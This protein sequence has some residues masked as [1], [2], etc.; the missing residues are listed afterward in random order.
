[1]SQI[2]ICYRRDD[3]GG[4]TGRLRDALS[5]EFGP[6]R[7]F[8]DLDTIGPGDDFI[9]AIERGVASCAVFLAIV[10]RSWL[11]AA[12]RDGHRRLDGP[13][14]HVRS[15]LTEALG[16][17]VRVIPVL[18]QGA[19][20]PQPSDLPDPLKPFAD[21]NAIALDDDDWS[22]DVQRLIQAIR[23][24]F[25]ESAAPH[26]VPA[27][28]RRRLWWAAA[29]VAVIAVVVIGLFNRSRAPAPSRS[30]ASPGNA[31]PSLSRA[32]SPPSPAGTP[33]QVPPPSTSPSTP[34]GTAAQVTLPAGGEA[35]LGQA[36]YEIMDA[37]V[38]T[39][40]DGR[41]L[42]LRIRLTN[43]GRYDE[44]FTDSAFRLQAGDE[45]YAPT[46]RVG[47]IVAGGTTKENVMVFQLPAS[48]AAA[49]L[50]VIGAGE[51]AEIPLDF[52]GRE[53]PTAAQAR[54]SRVS[55]KRTAAVPLDAGAARLRFGDLTC[56]VGRASVHRYANKLVLTLD[57]RA[58]NNGRYAIDFGDSH[59]RLVLDGESRAPV[60]GISVIVPAEGSLD[61][62]IVFD[63]PL[64]ARDVVIRARYGDGINDLPLK[65][66]AIR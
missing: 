51:T 64:S 20:M 35:G 4:H 44:G 25:G 55:G 11:T 2:F 61:G 63:M 66:P 65:I 45:G 31:S 29:A 14:D 22:S 17:G 9:Q 49:T 7:I 41:E 43:R 58:R 46:N 19:S 28:E 59:F 37:S 47:E 12:D 36:T 52:N 32:T 48:I 40:P 15:E 34:S 26:A 1:M 16:R 33:A 13:A 42:R 60:S 39:A 24:E 56:E 6:D 62:S 57:V 30:D 54:E 8:R 3:T 53:G 5:A 18:V 23:R 10:G 50:R 27:S 21:R 38:A